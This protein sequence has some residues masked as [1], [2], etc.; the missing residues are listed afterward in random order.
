MSNKG[1]ERSLKMLKESSDALLEHFDSVQ[2]FVTKY[3]ETDGGET[4]NLTFTAGNFFAILGQVQVWLKDQMFRMCDS[5]MVDEDE[6]F[7]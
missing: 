1:D 6:D 2:I 3:S 7:E 5:E 4:K